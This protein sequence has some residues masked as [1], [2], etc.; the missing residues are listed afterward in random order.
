[1][2]KIA[3][4]DVQNLKEKLVEAEAGEGDQVEKKLE[5]R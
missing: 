2:K 1:M 5:E 4:F 3:L